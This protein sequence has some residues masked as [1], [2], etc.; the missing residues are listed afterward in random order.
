L[1]VEMVRGEEF[2]LR[3]VAKNPLNGAKSLLV[4]QCRVFP[5][6]SKAVRESRAV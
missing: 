2:Y 3:K 5:E 4:K 1:G 6:V